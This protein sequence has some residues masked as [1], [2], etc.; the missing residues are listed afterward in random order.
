MRFC[1]QKKFRGTPQI[2]LTIV[3][4]LAISS[5]KRDNLC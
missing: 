4:H 5:R 2:V 3:Q 1:E